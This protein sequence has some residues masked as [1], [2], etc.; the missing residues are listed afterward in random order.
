MSK[1]LN[2]KVEIQKL[3][4]R[5]M[6]AVRNYEKHVLNTYIIRIIRYVPLKTCI[7]SKCTRNIFRTES[8]GTR[9]GVKKFSTF[10]SKRDLN[11]IS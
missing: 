11:S 1:V 6:C 7:V 3:V 5:M 4:F 9:Q 10:Q 2:R 8:R